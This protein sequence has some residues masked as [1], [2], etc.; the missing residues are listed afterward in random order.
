MS[1][2]LKE[3]ITNAIIGCIVTVIIQFLLEYAFGSDA[4]IVFISNKLTNG[5]YQTILS[6]KNINKYEYLKDVEIKI[7]DEIKIN[8]VIINGNEIESTEIIFRQTEPSEIATA[9]ITSNQKLRKEDVKIV[10]NNQSIELESLNEYTN[11]KIAYLIIIV[12]CVSISAIIQYFASKK[13]QQEIEKNK[14]DLQKI[15]EYAKILEQQEKT[16]EKINTSQRAIHIKE[17][18][19]MEKELEFYK[20][21]VY[22]TSDKKITKEELE[23]IVEK[24]L[25]LFKNKKFKRLDYASTFKLIMDITKTN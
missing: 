8:K 16:L 11:Y 23:K 14:D 6:L 3:T 20:N 19:D 7:S 24:E 2:L 25:K 22:K 4:K 12:I 9:I 10:K 15:G 1:K 5:E 13:F 21:L 17:I 18:G